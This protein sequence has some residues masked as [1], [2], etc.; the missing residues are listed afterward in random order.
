MRSITYFQS[1]GIVLIAQENIIHEIIYYN[2]TN[3]IKFILVPN[4][5][6]ADL[7]NALKKLKNVDLRKQKG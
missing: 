2:A 7:V 5:V 1:N 3:D 4:L 6:V